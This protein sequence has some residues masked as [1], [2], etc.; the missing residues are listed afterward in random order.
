MADYKHHHL[1]LSLDLLIKQMAN[2]SLN[3]SKSSDEKTPISDSMDL[4]IKQMGSMSI[5]ASQSIAEANTSEPV[6]METECLSDTEDIKGQL[7]IINAA[8]EKDGKLS[9]LFPEPPTMLPG[10]RY[11]VVTEAGKPVV[12]G[13]GTY[14]IIWLG[15]DNQRNSYVAIKGF[16]K[17]GELEFLYSDRA[18][19]CSIC[20]I[21]I[22]LRCWLK[23]FRFRCFSTKY[24]YNVKFQI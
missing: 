18:A 24:S 6:Q 4:L 16:K 7:K 23:R 1:Y 8:I 19:E 3:D 21:Y 11:E 14:G 20:L 13:E 5:T 17:I 2:L 10:S 15:I 12:V 9:K 22:V